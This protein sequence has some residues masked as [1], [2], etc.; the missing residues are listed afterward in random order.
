MWGGSVEAQE[1]LSPYLAFEEFAV[2]A[3]GRRLFKRGHPVR[4]QEQPFQMLL[5]LLE[6]PG[7]IVSRE[8]F[9]RRLWAEGTFVDFDNSLNAAMNKLREALDDSA[10]APRF[11]ETLPR[12]G[13]RFI[14]AVRP[15]EDI[16]EAAS[17]AP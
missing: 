7:E 4:I 1:V 11:V 17:A 12:R 5:V 16:L 8:E 14:A 3:A 10:D 2:D 9:R 6:R 13:Y 15:T